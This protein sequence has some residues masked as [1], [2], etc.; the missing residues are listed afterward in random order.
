MR[1]GSYQ[2]EM[3]DEG[4]M[5]DDI[6]GCLSVVI[7]NLKSCDL[8]AAEVIVWCSAMLE[9]DRVKFIARKSLEALRTQSQA[10]A[11]Q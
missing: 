1:Q 5:T 11:T 8:P 6:E 10:I 2:V 4:L 9:N 3:S 7:G